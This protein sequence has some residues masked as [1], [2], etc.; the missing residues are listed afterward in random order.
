MQQSNFAMP[1]LNELPALPRQSYADIEVS[2]TTLEY[3]R[4]LLRSWAH[5]IRQESNGY[6]CQTPFAD[7]G[8]MRTGFASA[9]PRGVKIPQDVAMLSGL[10][11][12]AENSGHAAQIGAVKIWY[13]RDKTMTDET[14]AAAL[15]YASAA[16]YRA[17]RTGGENLLAAQIEL[18]EIWLSRRL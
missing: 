17:A 7:G 13:L 6:P 15:S 18:A 4:D 12:F 3:V 14:I 1:V 11:E 9:I 5:W 16:E 8:A 10:I 2:A